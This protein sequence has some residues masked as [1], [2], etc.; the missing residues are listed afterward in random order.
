M[1]DQQQH[2]YTQIAIDSPN[3][4][5]YLLKHSNNDGFTIQQ[6]IGLLADK[7]ILNHSNKTLMKPTIRPNGI[8]ETTKLSF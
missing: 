4:D 7:T 8:R 6:P 1:T 3:V 2:W 5:E